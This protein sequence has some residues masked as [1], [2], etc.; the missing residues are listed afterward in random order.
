MLTPVDFQRT[1]PR[2]KQ[3]MTPWTFNSVMEMARNNAQNARSLGAGVPPLVNQRDITIARVV[4]NTGGLLYGGSILGI[5]GPVFTYEDNPN[6]FAFDPSFI[7]VLPAVSDHLDKFCILLEPLVDGELG[8]AAICG[9]VPVLVKKIRDF[10]TYA[11]IDEGQTLAMVSDVGGYPILWISDT[12]FTP[13]VYQGDDPN[14]KYYL[15]LVSI[16]GNSKN[17][18]PW[19]NTGADEVGEHGLLRVNNVETST[20]DYEAIEGE[21]PNSTFTREYRV[22]G[23]TAVATGT[24]GVY[25]RSEQVAVA[26]GDTSAPSVGDELGPKPSHWGAYKNY[27][28]VASCMGVLNDES[29]DYVILA[30]PKMIDVVIG[31]LAGSMAQGSTV[32]VNVWAGAGGSEAVVTGWTVESRDWLLKSGAT[33]VASGKK[34]AVTWVNGVPYILAAECN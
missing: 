17:I 19:Y 11:R 20:K 24:W 5:D 29:G 23:S 18:A 3:L 22:N 9:F 13:P 30:K 16:G 27:P 32:T 8:P 14:A 7:G 21:Q 26:V 12:E 4:N 1:E 2:N 10:H 28:A 33:A 6:E 15:A 31:K 34:A 25:Q